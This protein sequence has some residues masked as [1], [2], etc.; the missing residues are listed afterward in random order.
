MYKRQDMLKL[1]H[2]FPLVQKDLAVGV[3]DDG[4]LHNRGADDVVHLLGHHHGLTEKMC[5]RDR[6]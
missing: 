5:I 1:V 3:V 2:V 6:P 4:L